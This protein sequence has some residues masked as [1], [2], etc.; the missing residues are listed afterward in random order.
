MTNP[1]VIINGEKRDQLS[2][3]D[4]GLHYGDGLFETVAVINGQPRLWSSHMARLQ[5]GCEVLKLPQPDTAQMH[6][7]LIALCEGE[8]RAVVKIIYTRGSGG[9]GY[10]PPTSAE[11]QQIL[12]RYPWPDYDIPA[13]GISL[14][15]CHT[16]LACNPSLA[17][18]KHLNRLEQVMARAEWE[19]AS[20]HE[21]VMCDLNG[22]VK[23]GVMSNLFWVADGKL[24]SPDLTTCGVKGVMRE[25][26]LLVAESLGLAVEASEICAEELKQVDEIF[27]TNSLI[28]I[29][30]AAQFEG[31]ALRSQ[32]LTKRLQAALNNL[33]EKKA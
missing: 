33:L 6:K 2:V 27:L 31:V 22:N 30:P 26:V 3:T 16:P 28:G 23:E 13:E 11:P 18:L 29:W 9:R 5:R 1:V 24:Y 19:D 14:R 21:G 8:S 17:G 32:T 12:F 7:E 10:L 4:R 15:L 25:Q 20:I